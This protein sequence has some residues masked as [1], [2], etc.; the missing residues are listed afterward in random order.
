MPLKFLAI[1]VAS[2]LRLKLSFP[3]F[4]LN[5]INTCKTYRAS[6]TW[7]T[8]EQNESN[9]T[10]TPLLLWHSQFHA[11]FNSS[12][13][14]KDSPLNEFVLAKITSLTFL[15]FLSNARTT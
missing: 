15:N 2:K 8:L 9:L 6:S 14:N 10:D 12:S 1:I 3:Q 7:L 5:S 13:N 4:V 11:L